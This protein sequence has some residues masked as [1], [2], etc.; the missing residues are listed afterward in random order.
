[1]TTAPESPDTMK[2]RDYFAA[3]ALPA[4]W[5]AEIAEMAHFNEGITDR[6]VSERLVAMRA[7]RIADAMLKARKQ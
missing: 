6:D 7:Y 1:M 2:L 4:A 3:K 5:A